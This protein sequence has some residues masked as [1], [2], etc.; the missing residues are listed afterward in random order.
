MPSENWQLFK[1]GRQGHRLVFESELFQ[2]AAA[3]VRNEIGL[4]RA[5]G[6]LRA[7]PGRWEHFLSFAF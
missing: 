6:K 7:P 1:N 4:S 2:R 5:P 3:C